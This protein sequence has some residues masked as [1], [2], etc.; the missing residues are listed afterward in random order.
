MHF[1]SAH[2]LGTTN[3]SYPASIIWV[4]AISAI[5]RTGELAWW[6]NYGPK[7]WATAPGMDV[8][9][10]DRAG[11]AGKANGVLLFGESAQH[12]RVAENVRQPGHAA[13]ISKYHVAGFVAEYL[14][15]L[16]T[17]NPEPVLDIFLGFPLGQRGQMKAE[18]DSLCELLE[19]RRVE[20][21]RQFG[22]TGEDDPQQLFLLTLD[23]R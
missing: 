3:V 20:L 17:G 15:P 5:E 12:G 22:L 7:I 8:L 19:S 4:K 1:A 2:N 21:L 6:S 10:T 13:G 23:S 11:T 18:P 14:S 9:T 16:G